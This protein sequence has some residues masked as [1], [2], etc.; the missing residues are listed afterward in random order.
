[1]ATKDFPGF[2]VLIYHGSS[3]TYYA[4]AIDEIRLKGGVTRADLVMRFLLRKRHLAPT[5]TSTLYLAGSK[6][7]LV[8]NKVPDFLV[9]G[10]IHRCTVSSYNNILMLNCGCWFPQSDYQEKRGIEPEPARAIVVN[11]H[12]LDCKIIY[13]GDESQ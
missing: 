2:D 11:L 7:N 6:D 12:T 4:D 8:I 3:F 9:S 5:H 10:H 1:G 13:F